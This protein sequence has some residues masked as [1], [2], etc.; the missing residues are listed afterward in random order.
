MRKNIEISELKIKKHREQNGICP[1]CGALIINPGAGQLAHRI[2]QGKRN[3]KM[4]GKKIIHHPLNMVLACSGECNGL[5]LVDNHPVKKE[6]ILTEIKN[7]IKGKN[8]V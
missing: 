1:V 4:Y 6:E 7:A 5:L 8:N 2:G 3:M